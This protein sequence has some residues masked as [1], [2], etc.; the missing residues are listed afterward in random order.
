MPHQGGTVDPEALH[1]LGIAA[2]DELHG[3]ACGLCDP[4]IIGDAKGEMGVEVLAEGFALI[5]EPVFR[6]DADPSV[7]PEAKQ[8]GIGAAA[9]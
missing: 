4:I 9:R 2:L 5:G 7:I 1:S 6:Q 3:P 8:D